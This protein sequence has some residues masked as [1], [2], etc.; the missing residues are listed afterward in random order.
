MSFADFVAAAE[1]GAASIYHH[2]LATGVEIAAWGEDPVIAP[3]LSAGAAAA[4]AALGRAGIGSGTVTLVE[5]DIATGLKRIAAADPTV[6]SIGGISKL[7]GLAGT[8]AE[9][10][11]PALAPA[12]GTAEGAAA[13]AEALATAKTA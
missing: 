3:L 6:P 7:V 11:D 13:L 9:T 10:I 4:N 1:A 8:V 12:I 5:S 2:V